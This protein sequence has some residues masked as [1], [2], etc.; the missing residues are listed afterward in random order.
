[1]I[2]S[3]FEKGWIVGFIESKG[4]FTKNK[5]KIRRKTKTGAKKYI[6]FNPIF[7]LVYEDKSALEMIRSWLGIGKVNQHGKVYRLSVRKKDELLRLGEFL[8]GGFKSQSKT[9]QFEH[10][11]AQLLEWKSRAWGAGAKDQGEE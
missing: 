3:E 10:W 8:G 6:Y 5:V 7:Y 4:V 11:K 2:P 9:L 1:M